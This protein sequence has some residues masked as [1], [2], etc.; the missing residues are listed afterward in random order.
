MLL[1]SL[2][3]EN[4]AFLSLRGQVLASPL[5][6]WVFECVGG[7]TARTHTRGTSL[8][9]FFVKQEEDKHSAGQRSHKGK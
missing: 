8:T 9:S 6:M 4:F 5:L 7:N 2:W 3:G 1:T